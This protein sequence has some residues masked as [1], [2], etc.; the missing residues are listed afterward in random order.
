MK[1]TKISLVALAAVALAGCG[2]GSDTREN[3]LE[4]EVAELKEDLTEAQEDLTE[5]KED[6][7][8]ARKDLTEVREDLTEVREDLEEANERV[9]DVADAVGKEPFAILQERAREALAGLGRTTVLATSPT[10]T[11]KY[12]ATAGL[13]ATGGGP[14]SFSTT[15]KGSRRGSGRWYVS[16]FDDGESTESSTDYVHD[17]VVYSD[18][19]PK[20]PQNIEQVYSDS[21]DGISGVDRGPDGATDSW[22]ITFDAQ[23]APYNDIKSLIRASDFL[24]KNPES[25][26]TS[27]PGKSYADTTGSGFSGSF[28]GVQGS[29]KCTNGPCTVR[30]LRNGFAFTGG[31]WTF[32]TTGKGK[33]TVRV[34][35]DSYM[36]FG[37][38]R[39]EAEDGSL[40]FDFFSDGAA[41]F[42]L[43]ATE[44]ASLLGLGGSARYAGTAAG[45]FSIYDAAAG[46]DDPSSSGPFTA[47]VN[48]TAD[49]AGDT[50]EGTV[51]NFSNDESW[52]LTLSS[53]AIDGTG[54]NVTGGTTIWE[55]G[56]NRSTVG[57]WSAD[58]YSEDTYEGGVPDGVA[59]TFSAAFEAVPGTPASANRRLRGAFGAHKR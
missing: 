43:G 54:G 56:S 58:F 33:V 8:D 16:T 45:Q 44:A 19:G 36:Y 35:D 14:V 27:E 47:N 49:F 59:G 50:L 2:G 32:T 26:D 57:A 29:Y 31:T 22:V 41:N 6:L 55:I 28:D 24:S 11:P 4:K 15:D 34:D 23:G 37:W 40:D 52:S 10:V 3:E 39:R 53:R 25:G 51:N 13:T 12:Q 18:L 1:H 5:A 46:E 48:L 30:N 9:D 38:W 21:T 20:K 17:I 7:T 42:K